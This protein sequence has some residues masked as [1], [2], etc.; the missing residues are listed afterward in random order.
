MLSCLLLR[1]S[2]RCQIGEV[3][4]LWPEVGGRDLGGAILGPPGGG[5]AASPVALEAFLGG[6]LSLPDIYILPSQDVFYALVA[7][8][9]LGHLRQGHFRPASGDARYGSEKKVNPSAWVS[10]PF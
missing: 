3:E 9:T 7:P 10:Q 8:V 2:S 5:E 4:F 6:R 1:R